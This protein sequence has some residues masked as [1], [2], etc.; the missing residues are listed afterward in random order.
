MLPR[1]WKTGV[2][3][4]WSDEEK[5]QRLRILCDSPLQRILD[6]SDLSR[7]DWPYISSLLYG[8]KILNEL[9]MIR[10][11]STASQRQGETPHQWY[12]RVCEVVQR[13]LPPGPEQDWEIK[14]SFLR[15]LLQKYQQAIGSEKYDSIGAILER[16]RT[17]D[18]PASKQRNVPREIKPLFNKTCYSCG[19]KGHV[20]RDCPQLVHEY[21]GHLWSPWED[22]L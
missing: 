5:I 14:S 12:L 1:F 19:R 3:E 7:K 6:N 18:G 22:C 4:G 15:G 16:C 10:Y 9:S 11:L 8:E 17:V 13:S 2:D 21:S 20:Q